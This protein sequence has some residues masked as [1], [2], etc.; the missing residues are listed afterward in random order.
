MT[1]YLHSRNPDMKD[2]LRWAELEKQ[3][4]TQ[5]AMVRGRF[6]HLLL[7]PL[8]EDPEV[9]ASHLR[10]FLNVNLPEDAWDVFDGVE[11]ENG[12]EVWRVLNVNT[13]QKTQAEVL[14]L[15]DTVMLP[16]RLTDTKP[17][18]GAVVE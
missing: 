4:I 15:E 14:R 9:L 8:T 10:R 2:L 13:T 7:R 16:T 18:P 6:S 17:I 1:Y 11:V 5:A 12:L 3:L